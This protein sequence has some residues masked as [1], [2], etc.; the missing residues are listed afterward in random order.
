MSRIKQLSKDSIIYGLGGGLVKGFSFFLLPIYT[1]IFSPSD[2][3][4]IEMI[5]VITSFLSA[6]LIIG[7]D[8]AQSFLW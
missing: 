3:G 7:M 5:V 2:Y 6:I 8:S 4:K 1:S